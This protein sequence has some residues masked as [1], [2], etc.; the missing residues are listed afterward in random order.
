[1]VAF[2][3]CFFALPDLAFFRPLEGLTKLLTWMLSAEL[4]SIFIAIS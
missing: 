1:M 4:V 3:Y 2:R